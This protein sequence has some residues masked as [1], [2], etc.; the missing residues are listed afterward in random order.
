MTAKPAYLLDRVGAGDS[1]P[2]QVNAVVEIPKSGSVKYE[3]DPQTGLVFVDRF[4]YTAIHYPFNYGFI[5]GTKGEDGDYLDALVLTEEP[6]YPMSVIRSRIIGALLME[7]EGGPD[8][9]IVAVP[10]K[11]IDPAHS[12]L[13]DVRQLPDFTLK[14]MEYFSA[15]YKEEEPGKFVRVHRWQGRPAAEGL[16]RKAVVAFKEG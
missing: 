6:V 2:S 8:S 3:V 1:P 5:P 13:S 12:S 15:H 4:L 16:I 7:D 10:D 14:Q 9:K 11:N